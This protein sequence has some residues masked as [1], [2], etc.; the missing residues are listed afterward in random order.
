MVKRRRSGRPL[1]AKA[2]VIDEAKHR[3]IMSDLEK[4]PTMFKAK[5]API[6]LKGNKVYV[7]TIDSSGKP[8]YFTRTL[9]D[10]ELLRYRSGRWALTDMIADMGKVEVVINK[11][12]THLEIT[13][14]K[15]KG[16]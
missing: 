3:E 15:K 12:A 4:L 2:A 6:L 5:T 13:K 8:K 16:K 14:G 11:G 1:G 9:N 10:E 7:K